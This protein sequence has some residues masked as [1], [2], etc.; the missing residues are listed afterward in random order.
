[1]NPKKN[2]FCL[3]LFAFSVYGTAQ[4]VKQVPSVVE[5]TALVNSLLQQSKDQLA[6]DPAIA[7][8][9]AFQAK[10][11]SEKINFPLGAATAAKN[12]GL[13]YR[14]Q[15]KNLDALEYYN[16][17][18]KIF[19]EINDNA[20]MANLY[21]NIGVVYYSQGDDAKALENYLQSLKFSEQS[22]DKFRILIALNNIGGIYF[23]KKATYDKALQYYL[24]ALPISEE[25]G[26]KEETGAICKNIGSIYFK[27]DED[28]K[29]LFLF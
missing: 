13:G 21:S 5:D 14:K 16:Q 8:S 6:V 3:T 17:S 12:I 28:M 15:G 4:A 20:G 9:L 1:M 27:M 7:I 26:K 29:A 11:V 22:G 24:K 25:L 19:E 2:I 18:L 10:S 23:D